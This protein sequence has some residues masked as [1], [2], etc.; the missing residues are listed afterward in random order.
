[1]IDI[2]RL[3]RNVAAINNHIQLPHDAGRTTAYIALMLGEVD[4]G[5]AGNTYLYI[6]HDQLASRYA[7]RA[8][9]AYVVQEYGNQYITVNTPQCVHLT[10]NQRY[11][12]AHQDPWLANVFRG[13]ELA[14]VFADVDHINDPDVQSELYTRVLSMGGT[15]HHTLLTV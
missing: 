1:M 3:A 14:G 10:N 4:L 8:L 9:T 5:D 6:G 12:F 11:M 7:H 2:D 13:T 15:V